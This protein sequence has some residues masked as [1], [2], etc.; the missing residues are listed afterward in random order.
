MSLNKLQMTVF[1]NLKYS[2]HFVFGNNLMMFNLWAKHTYEWNP[3][4]NLDIFLK[5]IVDCISN[6]FF[7][8]RIK[9]G[10]SILEIT[11]ITSLILVFPSF[12]VMLGPER[13]KSTMKQADVNGVK[14]N[15]ENNYDSAMYNSKFLVI[16]L[17]LWNLQRYCV[18]LLCKQYCLLLVCNMQY[19]FSQ[20]YGVPNGNGTYR[21]IVELWNVKCV[22]V[23]ILVQMCVYI[24]IDD[25]FICGWV[26]SV[27]VLPICVALFTECTVRIFLRIS[28]FHWHVFLKLWKGLVL[29]Q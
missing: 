26:L 23:Y 2:K 4:I 11:R 17:S 15:Q 8:T 28:V 10:Q 25:V 14:L 21:K 9:P 18:L 5:I 12:I 1:G 3:P 13:R 20:Q 19:V 6:V 7:F 24:S 29:I 16:W 27:G 22:S